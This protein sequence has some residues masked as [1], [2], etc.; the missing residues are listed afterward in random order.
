MVWI[1]LDTN[2]SH[3][4]MITVP[5]HLQIMVSLPKRSHEFTLFTF[6]LCGKNLQVVIS[7][8]SLPLRVC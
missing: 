2:D 4:F 5:L 7:F 1:Q 6:T 3:V 8:P